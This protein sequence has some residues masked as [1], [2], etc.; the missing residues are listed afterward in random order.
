[1]D[2]RR[3]IERAARDSRARLLAY[4]SARTRDLAAAE[5][6]LADAFRKALES[7]P[8]TGV[9]DRPE[10]WLM[11]TAR[12]R[13]IDLARRAQVRDE[14]RATLLAVTDEADESAGTDMAFPDERLKL[15]FVC[16]RRRSL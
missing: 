2:A 10:A 9:P 12:H 16:A 14:A 3:E 1:M 13:L 8:Q 4:L 6:A 15:L 5:D 7:W 11:T